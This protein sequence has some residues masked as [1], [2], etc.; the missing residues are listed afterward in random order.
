MSV[1]F[2]EWK[3]A[4]ATL[5][6]ELYGKAVEYAPGLSFSSLARAH[7]EPIERPTPENTSMR[8]RWRVPA[9]GSS[10]EVLVL[11]RVIYRQKRNDYYTRVVA[12]IARPLFVGLLLHSP[13]PLDP[14]FGTPNRTS[15]EREIDG[16]FSFAAAYPNEALAV[17]RR[18]VAWPNDVVDHLV[19]ASERWDEVTITDT[20][21]RPNRRCWR[22]FAVS[23]RALASPSTPT[24]WPC[25]DTWER[26][27]QSYAPSAKKVASSPCSR[28]HPRGR[29]T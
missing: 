10:V 27:P 21:V 11:R 25:A 8:G 19:A 4:A 5:G 18:S 16:R 2:D 14:L 12:R 9:A 22:R 17:L 23:G 29:W 24:R 15:G 3:R 20:S 26:S 6:L 7:E 1:T 28:S 13:R